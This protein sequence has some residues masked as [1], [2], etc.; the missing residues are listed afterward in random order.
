MN[1]DEVICPC[2]GTT[3]RDIM[4]A[5]E[6]GANTVEDIQAI[7]NAGTVCGACINDIEAL[8]A[9]LKNN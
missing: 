7:T 6:N 9:K 2:I 4:D 5:V 1:E 8:L 3:V